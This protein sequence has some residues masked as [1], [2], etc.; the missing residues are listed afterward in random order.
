MESEEE[1]EFLEAD[2]GEDSDEDEELM[3]QSGEVDKEVC[4]QKQGEDA[5]G[6]C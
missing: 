5:S 1:E 3:L 2:F 6:S 4:A